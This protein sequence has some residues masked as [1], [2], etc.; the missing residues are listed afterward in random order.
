MNFGL[1]CKRGPAACRPYR[2]LITRKLK[3]RNI[4]HFSVSDFPPTCTG[5][6]FQRLVLRPPN[7]LPGTRGH[8]CLLV[9]E[10]CVARGSWRKNTFFDCRGKVN[11]LTCPVPK[12]SRA[13]SSFQDLALQWN[14]G[15]VRTFK[16]TG[17]VCPCLNVESEDSLCLQLLI[18]VSWESPMEQLLFRLLSSSCSKNC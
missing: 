17:L 14:R 1:E 15:W 11:K 4:G 8:G 5:Q 12:R 6:I 13:R 16:I 7:F 10:G 2:G 3:I 18:S 9:G